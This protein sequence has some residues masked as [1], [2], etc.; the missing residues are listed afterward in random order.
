MSWT[1]PADLRA[2]VQRLWDRGLLL[3]ALA[4]GEP[5]FPRRLTLK[6]PTSVELADR[7][8]EARSWIGRIRDEAKFYRVVWRRVNH[9]ILGSNEMPA[10]IWIDSLENGLG[11][12]GRRRDGERFTALVAL[13]RERQPELLTWLAKRPLRGLELGD[14]W[15]RLLDI[16]AWLQCHP[17]PG[18][19]LRQVDIPGVHSKFIEDHRW[20]LGELFELV[21]APEAIEIT[22]GGVSGF[23]RRYGFC[24][25]PLRLRFRILDP[26]LALL[27]TG[28]DQDITVTQ[29]AFARLDLPVSRVFITENEINFLAFPQATQSMVVFGAGYGFEILAEADWLRARE[30]HYW[31]DLDTHGFAILDQLRG[32]LPRAASFLMDQETL[33]AHRPLWETEPHPETRDLPRL[34]DE[35]RKVY[36]ELRQNRWGAGVRLEQEKIGFTWLLEALGKLP[37]PVQ[38]SIVGLQSNDNLP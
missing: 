3:A 34:T 31:G 5:P 16:V 19:Y 29:T 8:V 6:G 13:T 23:C 32:H 1:T 36:D 35:E 26:K 30:I 10:E 17:R 38:E 11:L 12:I 24:D 37:L 2:Q 21:L 28:T 27:P 14:D 4:G 33:L 9:R 7:F 25:K 20:V 18:V 15:P 22:V